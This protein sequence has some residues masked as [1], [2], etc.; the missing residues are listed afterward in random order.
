M[1]K[2]YHTTDTYYNITRVCAYINYIKIN[3]I[4]Y[5]IE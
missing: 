2:N 5:Y 1:F 4:V 3:E